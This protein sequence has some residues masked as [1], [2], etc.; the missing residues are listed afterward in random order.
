MKPLELQ[1]EPRDLGHCMGD[2]F[3]VDAELLGAPTHLH[4]GRLELEVRVDA[5]RHPRCSNKTLPDRG[6]QAELTKRLDVDQ[7]ACGHGLRQLGFRL[8]GT[9]EADFARVHAGVECHP[10]LDARSHV[11]PIDETRHVA[12]DGRHRV[13]LDRVMQADLRGQYGAES[14]D[15]G[16]QELAVVGVKRRAAD[17]RRQQRQRQAADAQLFANQRETFDGGVRALAHCATSC[18]A[19]R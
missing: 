3:G 18:A 17:T 12:D 15:A 1:A 8:S 13:G 11:Q 19:L 9:G 2:L 14:F 7:D 4:A 10:Q 16:R 6:Q 5:N